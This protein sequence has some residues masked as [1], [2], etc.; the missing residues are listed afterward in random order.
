MDVNFHHVHIPINLNKIF[1]V[2]DK[3]IS[4]IKAYASNVYQESMMHYHKD[5]Q[6]ADSKRAE[7]YA[8]LISDQNIFVNLQN[9]QGTLRRTLNLLQVHC[10]GQLPEFQKDN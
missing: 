3:A 4:K 1:Q 5:N 6:Y 10:L 8:K 7:G 2:A 9:P